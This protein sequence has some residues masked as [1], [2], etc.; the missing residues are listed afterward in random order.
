MRTPI[1]LQFTILSYLPIRHLCKCNSVCHEWY[2]IIHD[3][4]FIEN[5]IS[6]SGFHHTFQYPPPHCLFIV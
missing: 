6:A 1:E 4:H 2:D 5:W 3:M